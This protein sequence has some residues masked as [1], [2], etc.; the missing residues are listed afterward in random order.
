M[1]LP[2]GREVMQVN[3]SETSLQFR[4]IFS[5]RE[6]SRYGISLPPEATIFDVGAN[7]GISSLFFLEEYPDSV[8]HAYEPAD[9]MHAALAANLARFGDQALAHR[10][11]VGRRPGR[12]QLTVYPHTTAMSSLYADAGDD[13]DV[14]RVFLANCGFTARDVDALVGGRYQGQAESCEVTTISAEIARLGVQRLD[15]LKIN[16]EK[17]EWDVLAGIEEPDWP[18]VQQIV[19]QV[20]DLDGRLGLVVRLLKGRGFEVRWRQD[21]LLA[22]T[23]I[24]DLAAR[25]GTP[26]EGDR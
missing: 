3:P 12:A 25:R 6:Y 16:V 14:T 2:D 9:V 13:E 5:A 26:P 1:R 22:G 18:I 8:L 11:A 20:H 15:L 21:P 7:V 10:L 24:H 4:N 23:N 17:A 19:M